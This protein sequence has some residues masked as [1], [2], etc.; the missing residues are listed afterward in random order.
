MEKETKDSVG[1]VINLPDYKNIKIQYSC[2]NYITL[3]SVELNLKCWVS[4]VVEL[5]DYDRKINIMRKHIG[6]HVR[7]LNSEYFHRESITD[8]DIKTKGLELNKNSFC[9][10]STT[11]FVKKHF[12]FKKEIVVR[13]EMNVLSRQIIDEMIEDNIFYFQLT[14]D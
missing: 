2:I 5:D 9:D 1:R 8:I 3:K 10:I 4:P 13:T 14:K 7:K 11:I 12:D 6:T